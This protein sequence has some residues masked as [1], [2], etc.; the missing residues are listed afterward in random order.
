[1]I[2]KELAQVILDKVHQVMPH[3]LIICGTGGEVYAA[4]IKAR[5]GNIHD[6]SKS[7][8]AGRLNESVITPE[9]Q[10]EYLRQGKDVRNGIHIPIVV[11]GEKIATVGITGDPPV[12]RPYS[13]MIK[14]MIELVYEEALVRESI[15]KTHEEV[16]ESFGELAATSQ[17]LYASAEMIAAANESGNSIVQEVTEILTKVKNNL[18]LIDNIAKKTNLI[19][20]NAA[21]ES[22][23][24]G[25]HGRSFAVV[26]SEIKKLSNDT[27]EYAHK[28][29][30][31]NDHF[32]AKFQDILKIIDENHAVSF[33]QKESLKVLTEKTE[34]IKESLE[35]LLH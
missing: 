22:A 15:V 3:P 27:S 23:R 13:N 31:L 6:I 5:V 18:M 32:A 17:S 30:E 10:E 24:A 7:I 20:V 12:V 35:S 29:T 33:D 25:V 4:S 34:S 21:I 26:A 2:S 16:N 11:R 9:M 14:L 28:I 19:S 8:L 1:M